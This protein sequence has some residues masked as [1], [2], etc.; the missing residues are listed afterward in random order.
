ME[1][2]HTGQE[3]TKPKVEVKDRKCFVCNETSHSAARCPKG[4]LK[5]LTRGPAAAQ[6]RDRASRTAKYTLCLESEG[7]FM[8]AHRLARKTTPWA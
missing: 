4:K 2:G 7:G 5:A 6:A 3:C 1:K 8:P